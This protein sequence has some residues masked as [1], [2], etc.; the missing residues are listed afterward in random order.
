MTA[1]LGQGPAP[2][3]SSAHR[4]AGLASLVVSIAVATL[5]LYGLTGRAGPPTTPAAVQK[6]ICESVELLPEPLE[7]AQYLTGLVLLPV[8]LFLFYLLF[9]VPAARLTAPRAA[10]LERR[11]ESLVSAG[12]IGILVAGLSLSSRLV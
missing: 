12:A 3:F 9:R 6:Q 1:G 4:L 10:T 8:L 7:R 5:I 11:V 2:A